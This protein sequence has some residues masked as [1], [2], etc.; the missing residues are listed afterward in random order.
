MLP[1]LG[2]LGRSRRS[3][4]LDVGISRQEQGHVGALALLALVAHRYLGGEGL[5]GLHA[6]RALHRSDDEVRLAAHAQ[7]VAGVGVVA[8]DELGAGVVRVHHGAQVPGLHERRAVG[9][10]R[11]GIA[12]DSHGGA[13]ARGD[14]GD[15]R[16]AN[17]R[18]SG[19]LGELGTRMVVSVDRNRLTSV[20]SPCWP[21]LH[22]VTWAVKDW[23]YCTLAG[24]SRR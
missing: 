7:Q 22:T 6:G 2:V 20:L 17:L 12:R 13:L 16:V 4:D 3:G 10:G 23:P 19:G 14:I 8:L 24:P 9:G 1:I 18:V 21:W 11:V 5:T 15:V